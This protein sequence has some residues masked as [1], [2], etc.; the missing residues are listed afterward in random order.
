MEKKIRLEGRRKKN[1]VQGASKKKISSVNFAKKIKISFGG[2]PKKKIRSR[3]SAPRP[4]RWLMVD[5]LTSV[6]QL[7]NYSNNKGNLFFQAESREEEKRELDVDMESI[8]NQLK[9]VSLK[10][11]QRRELSKKRLVC[12]FCLDWY[13]NYLSR[14][15]S[16][17]LIQLCGVRTDPAVTEIVTLL[18]KSFG[19]ILTKTEYY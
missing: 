19:I 4:P 6:Q 1:S 10:K 7:H 2:S 14:S 3:K 11:H 16:L 12:C 13:C 17:T 8:T 18:E 5:P 9:D 15:A